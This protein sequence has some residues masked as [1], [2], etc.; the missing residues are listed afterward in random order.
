MN[1]IIIDA[2][3]NQKV[4]SF[5][6]DGISRTVEPHAYGIAATGNELLRCFQVAGAHR[7]KTGTA[8]DWDLLIVSK[9]ENLTQTG[10][11]FPGARPGYNKSDKAMARIYAEL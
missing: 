8:H 11:T 3:Q 7:N 1:S 10:A 2:I 4:L 5:T 9:I 6:Y